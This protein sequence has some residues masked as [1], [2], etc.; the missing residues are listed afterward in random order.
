M[1]RTCLYTY[2]IRYSL[3]KYIR[4]SFNKTNVRIQKKRERER[5]NTNWTVKQRKLKLIK[6]YNKFNINRKRFKFNIKYTNE[7]K[8][9]MKFK[10]Q[11]QQLQ[12]R[13]LQLARHLLLNPFKQKKL[14]LLNLKITLLLE[15]PA[16]IFCLLKRWLIKSRTVA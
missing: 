9:K 14:D 7:K 15:H 5:T 13:P 12:H 8:L 16:G 11:K 1:K 3:L 2:C 10:Q 6:T 4:I